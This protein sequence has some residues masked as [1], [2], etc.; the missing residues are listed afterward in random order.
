MV[1]LSERIELPE[2]IREK[3]LR[4]LRVTTIEEMKAHQCWDEIDADR[5]VAILEEKIRRMELDERKLCIAEQMM[6]S[7]FSA[8]FSK[9]KGSLKRG[10]TVI[11]DGALKTSKLKENY[12]EACYC[13]GR[14]DVSTNPA[15]L[16]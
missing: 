15:Y 11:E 12:C 6:W 3:S 8:S 1:M 10:H 4:F 13:K 16:L 9:S 14:S 2:D 7:Y 5:V